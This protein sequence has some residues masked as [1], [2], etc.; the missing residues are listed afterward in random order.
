MIWNILFLSITPE[1]VQ[2]VTHK[3]DIVTIGQQTQFLP[4]TGLG[5]KMKLKSGLLTF[6]LICI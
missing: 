1:L 6:C 5:D 4:A 3:S 2:V